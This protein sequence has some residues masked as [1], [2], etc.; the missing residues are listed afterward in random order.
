M[1][2]KTLLPAST[3]SLTGIVPAVAAAAAAGRVKC[4]EKLEAQPFKL[5]G[6]SQFTS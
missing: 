6:F 5:E 4:P 2:A 1:L 3:T